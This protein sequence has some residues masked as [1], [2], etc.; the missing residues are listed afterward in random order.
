MAVLMV[1][2]LRWVA[3]AVLLGIAAWRGGLEI[4]PGSTVWIKLAVA[5][6]IHLAIGALS[7]WGFSWVTNGLTHDNMGPQQWSW[8]FGVVVP[9]PVLLFTW[10]AI[11]PGF[12][13]RSPKIA[14][15]LGLMVVVF[16][17]WAFKSNLDGMRTR[18]AAVVAE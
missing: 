3:I 5:L 8:F 4:L 16:H 10:W 18:R 1:L 11:N 2:I 7:G 9:L 17:A 6:G 12:A 13:A 14:I 15:A